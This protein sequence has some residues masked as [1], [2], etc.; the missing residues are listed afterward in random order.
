MKM[1]VAGGTGFLGRELCAALVRGGHGVRAVSRSVDG[2]RRVLPAGT[3]VVALPGTAAGWTAVVEGCEAIVNLAGEP[4]AAGRWSE[5]RK[6]AILAS[7]VGTTRALVEGCAGASARPATL[8]NGSAIGYY[9]DRGDETVNEAS[10]PGHGFL[11]R[12]CVEWEAAAS[13]AEKLGM[14]VVRLRIGVVLGE[15][16]GALQRMVVPFKA[17]LGGPLGTGRQWLSWIHRDDVIGLIQLALNDQGVH[18]ALNLTAPDPRTMR[19]FSAALGRAMHRPSWAPVPGFVLRLAM[20]E[21]ADMILGGQRVL[22]AVAE[23]VGYRFRYPKLEDA[24]GA[25]LAAA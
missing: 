17:F 15:G 2:A 20:G 14:R 16:G 6:E 7:R 23:K 3:E 12:V 25:V 19:D 5:A 18:G 11:A 21:M 1:L 4:I 8:I 13:G 10:A 22:P 24:L 9:G